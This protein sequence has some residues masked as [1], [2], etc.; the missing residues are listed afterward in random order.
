[1][2][3]PVVK[4]PHVHSMDAALAL[5]PHHPTPPRWH[6]WRDVSLAIVVAGGVIAPFIWSSHPAAQAQQSNSEKP[7]VY[8][9]VQLHDRSLTT[10][11]QPEVNTVTEAMAAAATQTQI[12]FADPTSGAWAVFLNGVPVSNP[13]QP[14]LK[15]D[16]I[17][18][19][20]QQ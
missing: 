18:T 4:H 10:T 15:P 11:V 3:S 20:H 7:L 2:N 14:T 5:Q 19:I 8:V 17:L 12:A 6:F 13:N 16:D 9:E 1:M